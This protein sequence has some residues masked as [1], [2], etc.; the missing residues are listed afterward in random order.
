[1]H[2]CSTRMTY[3][4]IAEVRLEVFDHEQADRPPKMCLPPAAMVARD[5]RL[6]QLPGAVS[7]GIRQVACTGVALGIADRGC[8]NVSYHQ[9]SWHHQIVPPP[10]LSISQRGS[11]RMHQIGRWQQ[12]SPHH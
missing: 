4:G 6:L 3:A 1:M 2:C 12:H 7:A 5:L 8:F 10:P 11:K 9:T